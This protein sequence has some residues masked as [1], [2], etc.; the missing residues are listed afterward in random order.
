[1]RRSLIAILALLVEQ[2]CLAQDWENYTRAN[3]PLASNQVRS[4]AI[5]QVGAKWF[6]TDSGVVV[7]H[8]D[9]WQRYTCSGRL[10]GHRINDIA[11]VATNLG[12]EVWLATDEGIFLFNAIHDSAC[13]DSIF[14]SENSGLISNSVNAV[15]IDTGSVKWFGTDS[16]V[17]IFNWSQWRSFTVN[18]YLLHNYI[19][20]LTAAR[21][22]WTYLG[23]R[24]RGVNRLRLDGFDVVTSASPYDRQWSGLASD[25]VYCAFIDGAGNQWFGTN[26]GVSRHQGEETKRDWT[27]YN[28]RDGLAHDLVLAIGEDRRGRMWFGTAQGVSCF[29]GSQWQSFDSTSGL[30]GNWVYDIAC[31]LDGS[32][33]FGTN[34]GVSHYTGN[35]TNVVRNQPIASI[36]SSIT[37]RVQP[38]PC[39]QRAVIQCLLPVDGWVTLA[40]YNLLG[41]KVRTMLDQP[42]PRG[43]IAMMWNG[44]DDAGRLLPVGI[45]WLVIKMGTMTGSHKLIFLR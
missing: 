24:G 16:G 34:A 18:D 2:F 3:S 11:L 14:N 12:Q 5:D 9:Q 17:S 27:T 44:T 41:Q 33:W 39:Q 20:C 22:G 28:Q 23:T 31:D 7:L 19:L 6:G 43:D 1:M 26:R 45:Y 21:D 30:A 38:N 25:T 10:D 40:I 36:P 8:E 35:C 4:V 29:D 32:L 42:L 37:L 15:V 13:C